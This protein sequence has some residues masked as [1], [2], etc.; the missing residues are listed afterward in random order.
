MAWIMKPSATMQ[1]ERRDEPYL[2][3]EMKQRLEAEVLPRYPR[4]Q[5]ATLPALHLVQ[6]AYNF[7]PF[8]ACEEIAAF[9]ELS[10]A[11][12]FDAASFYDEFT[13]QPVGKYLLMVCQSL[14]CEL[15]GQ[16]ELMEN[17]SDKLGIEPGQTTEDGRVTLKACECLG[18]CG[19]APAALINHDLHEDI[20]WE[21]LSK[22]IDELE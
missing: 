19:T 16:V 6:D 10:A 2:T 3:A 22:T 14:S 4:K 18:S 21:R 11:E 13:E 20:T 7:V 9:L 5:A 15:C 1:I 17:L 12:V 8:Q